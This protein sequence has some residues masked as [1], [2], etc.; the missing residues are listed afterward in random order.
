MHVQCMFEMSRVYTTAEILSKMFG[1]NRREIWD[2]IYDRDLTKYRFGA[3]FFLIKICNHC[4]HDLHL[5]IE[6]MV[7]NR[8]MVSF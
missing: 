7:S 5:Y 8:E 3:N 2:L 6:K 4:L 1:K